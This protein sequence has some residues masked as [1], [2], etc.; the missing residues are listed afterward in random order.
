MASVATK[1]MPIE[2]WP[3]EGRAREEVAPELVGA[4]RVRPARVLVC[5]REVDLVRVDVAEAVRPDP[6]DDPEARDQEQYRRM[7][8][9][10]IAAA[11]APLLRR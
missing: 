8:M 3:S 9:K 6:G 10:T 5:L 7:T 1:P 2:T 11:T 4:E